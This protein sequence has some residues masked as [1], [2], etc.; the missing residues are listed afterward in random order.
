M[1]NGKRIDELEARMN[2][3][4]DGLS[5]LR[6]KVNILESKILPK[7]L[8]LNKTDSETGIQWLQQA[9]DDE[10]KVA[11]QEIMAKEHANA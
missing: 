2:Y 4:R 9:T 11:Y 10:I 6:S 3:F 8:L 5:A 1:F 7:S